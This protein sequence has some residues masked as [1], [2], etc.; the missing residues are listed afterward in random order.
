MLTALSSA[1]RASREV[2][3]L[4]CPFVIR[5]SAAN[6]SFIPARQVRV[7]AVDPRRDQAAQAGVGIILADDLRRQVNDLHRALRSYVISSYQ[8]SSYS[9]G[10]LSL[11]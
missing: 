1:L 5:C 11:K 6:P 10:S 2:I 7:I 8:L 9:Q 4:H 3:I